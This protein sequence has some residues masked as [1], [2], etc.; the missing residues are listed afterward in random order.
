M[1]SIKD[2]RNAQ[3]MFRDSSTPKNVAQ[4]LSKIYFQNRF[5]IYILESLG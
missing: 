1:G 3:N 2:Q 4:K 5:D